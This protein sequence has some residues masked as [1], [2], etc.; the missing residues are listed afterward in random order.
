MHLYLENRRD[1]IN[2]F[3]INSEMNFGVFYNAYYQRFVRYAFYYVN[4]LQAAEDLTHDALLYY[5]EN[6]HKLPA[7]ADVLGY[8]LESVKNKCLNYLALKQQE[9]EIRFSVMERAGIQLQNI[10]PDNQ[11]PLGTLIKKELEHKIQEVIQKLPPVC[12]QVFM[13]S[14]FREMSYEEISQELGI[15]VNTVKYHIK[16]ALVVL[17]KEFGTFLCIFLAFYP[18]LLF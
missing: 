3:E 8:I 2:P 9:V 7:D 1:I 16:N 5:W 14:R 15:S 12:K 4:D 18:T 6:K 10:I 11:Q 17:K 13:M